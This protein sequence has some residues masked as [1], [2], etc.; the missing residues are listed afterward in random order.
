MTTDPGR[1]VAPAGVH[2]LP[3][4]DG[5]LD[6]RLAAAFADAA[7]AAAADG[8]PDLPLLLVGMDTPQ[9]TAGHVGEACDAL[10][11]PGTDAV[12]GPADDGGWWALGLRRPD[13]S[14]LVGVPMSTSRT[15]AAQ[16]ARL[17][18]AGLRVAALPQLR[19]VDTAADLAAVARGAPGTRTAAL[20][21][22][23]GVVLPDGVL[24]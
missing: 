23:L 9:A 17:R 6:V 19:D 4:A 8:Q 12:L 2:R 14:L 21:R 15:H 20:A 5:A 1:A 10:L 18:G 16:V 7:A 22:R 3:Q 13:A 24:R 11:A